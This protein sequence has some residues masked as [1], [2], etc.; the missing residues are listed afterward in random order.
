M[1]I[2][3]C[4]Q[5]KHVNIINAKNIHFRPALFNC[6]I[7][8]YRMANKYNKCHVLYFTDYRWRIS[9]VKAKQIHGFGVMYP[10]EMI[11]N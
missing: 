5:S 2:E 4:E 11:K 7:V 9:L 8:W 10:K 1:Q 6:C 3:L